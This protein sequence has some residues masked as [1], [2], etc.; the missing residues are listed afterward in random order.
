MR[1]SFVAGDH[2]YVFVLLYSVGQ[3]PDYF[4][5]P[6]KAVAEYTS[7]THKVWLGGKK[8]DG[9]SRK[10]TSMREFR[11]DEGKFKEAWSF[12]GL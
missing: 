2:Y 1:E 3:R 9:G 6:S 8:R 5:V 7:T 11:D 10:D 12:L 4:I